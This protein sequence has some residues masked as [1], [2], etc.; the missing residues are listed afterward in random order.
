MMNFILG[1]LTAGIIVSVAALARYL[2]ESKKRQGKI[3]F[4]Q[5]DIRICP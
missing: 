1:F 2:H 3:K 4:K 5:P